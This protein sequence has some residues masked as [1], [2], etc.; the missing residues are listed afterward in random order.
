[1]EPRK[2]EVIRDWLTPII[3]KKVRGFIGFINFYRMFIKGFG[4]IVKS[5]YW[6]TEKDQ[7]FNWTTGCQDVFI[8]LKRLV[9]EEPVL[10]LSDPIEP[11][12]VEI[13]VSDYVIRAQL[14]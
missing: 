7:E 8:T 14:R 6:L 3:V 4:K 11:F 9:Y 12:K 1:M 5:L 10:R 2:I 13:D